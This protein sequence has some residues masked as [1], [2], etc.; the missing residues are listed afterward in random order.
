MQNMYN[1]F[2]IGL[3]STDLVGKIAVQKIKTYILASSSSDGLW[4]S[5]NVFEEEIDFRRYT[6]NS[7]IFG[8]EVDEN[9]K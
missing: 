2:S 9:E 7:T 3:V 4:K 6:D 1:N 5:N 8:W